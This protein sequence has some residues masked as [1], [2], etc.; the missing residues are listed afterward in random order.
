MLLFIE[1]CFGDWVYKPWSLLITLILRLRGVRVGRNL[2]VNGVPGIKSN[3][4]AGNILIGDNVR[5]FGN[6][7]LRVRENARI[8]LENGV[9][10]DRNC[11]IVAANEA[12]VKLCKR[13]EVGLHTVINAGTDITI[14]E[15]TMLGGYCYLQSSNHGTRRGMTI[16]SQQHK[17]APISIGSDVWLGGNVTVLPGASI[18]DGAILGAKS[19]VGG[20]VPEYE[21]WAGVPAKFI[22][23]RQ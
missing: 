17:Y 6:V 10:L 11:R 7:D 23:S 4:R 19:V 3:G 12:I 5:L 16:K 2:L 15:D 8:I 18:G 13:V 1:L 22:K 20:N 14:G 9:Y 21:M